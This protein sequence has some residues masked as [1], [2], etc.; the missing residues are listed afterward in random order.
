[1]I[2]RFKNPVFKE[3]SKSVAIFD[4][5]QEKIGEF[6]RVYKNTIHRIIEYFMRN[7]IMLNVVAYNSNLNSTCKI[8]EQ[9]GLKTLIRRSKWDGVSSTIGDFT[10]LDKT[11]IRTNQRLEIREVSGG[12][13]YLVKKDFADKR[14]FIENT[15][16]E[17]IAK[18]IYD[19]LFP[20]QN[21]TIHQ[22]SEELSV[23]DIVCLF[24]ILDKRD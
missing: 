12:R 3:S 11:V 5:N 2:Y 8:T 17:I 7:P 22:E 4:D 14:V 16:G 9:F 23:V 24:F 21:I 1:M 20:P 18:V 6:K 10:I 15:N 13:N 19:K